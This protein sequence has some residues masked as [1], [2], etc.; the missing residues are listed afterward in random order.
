MV[1]LTGFAVGAVEIGS[2]ICRVIG[3]VSALS[4]SGNVSMVSER[5][6][7]PMSADSALGS[8]RTLLSPS[9]VGAFVEKVSS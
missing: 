6:S 4:S 2:S 9:A 1:G 8:P 5:S 7:S 3:K